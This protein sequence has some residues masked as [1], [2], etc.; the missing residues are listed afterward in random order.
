MDHLTSMTMCAADDANRPVA[1]WR[2][3]D[4]M[5]ITAYYNAACTP[6]RHRPVI[7]IAVAYFAKSSHDNVGAR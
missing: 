5:R 2:Q 4:R 7:G 1:A 6:T 3:G